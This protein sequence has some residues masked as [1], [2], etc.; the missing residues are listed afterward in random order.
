MKIISNLAHAGIH[1]FESPSRD[2][3][4]LPLSLDQLL[5]HSPNSTYV[6]QAIGRS[7]EA[8]GIFDRDLLIINRAAEVKDIEIIV[9]T[10]NSLF[11]CKQYDKKNQR[12]YSGNTEKHYQLTEGDNFILEGVVISCIRLF[13]TPPALK[14]CFYS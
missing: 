11:V 8:Y 4:D 10:L 14:S 1:G 5:I 6:A 7:M 12:L 13:H 2:Y 9:A 3:I